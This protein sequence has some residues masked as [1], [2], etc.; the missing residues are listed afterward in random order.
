MISRGSS[1]PVR[2]W[3]ALCAIA[4][5]A[6]TCAASGCAAGRGWSRADTAAQFAFAAT[7]AIDEV[8]TRDWIAPHCAE[9]NPIIGQC[10]ENV[11]VTV[12]MAG[13]LVLEMTV[14]A[15]LPPSW[16][17]VFE[18]A[19]LGV[20]GDVIWGNWMSLRQTGWKR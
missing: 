2:W 15:M 12:Y 4:A 10:G 16:R 19:A 18:G 1:P 13:A 14:A 17:R 8:Q 7:Q 5:L 9:A 20:E 3:L 6:T 11:P